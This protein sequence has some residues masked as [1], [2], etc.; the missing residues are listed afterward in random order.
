MNNLA[1]SWDDSM[2]G[3]LLRDFIQDV[4]GGN[5][6]LIL[7]GVFLI[8]YLDAMVIT[9]LPELLILELEE[10]PGGGRE[11]FELLNRVVPQARVLLTSAGVLPDRSL[12]G[13]QTGIMG[14]LF[15]PFDLDEVM[16]G[17]R[18]AIDGKEVGPLPHSSSTRTG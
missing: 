13:T 12:I 16:H 4:T 1:P 14:V 17:V 15:K 3:G 6:Y 11:S 18:N 10:L 5:I 2:I 7:L 8:F 9:I